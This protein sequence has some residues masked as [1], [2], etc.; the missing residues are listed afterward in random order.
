M[1]PVEPRK[2]QIILLGNDTV[3]EG[4]M[5]GMTEL[6]VGQTFIGRYK[7]ITDDLNLRLVRNGLQIRMEDAGLRVGRRGTMAVGGCGGGIEA[8]GKLILSVGGGMSL[9]LQDEDLVSVESFLKDG[10]VGIWKRSAW[11]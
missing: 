6:D 4:P 9:V 8:L 5:V 11:W 10:E 3:M 1:P 2:I 7:T